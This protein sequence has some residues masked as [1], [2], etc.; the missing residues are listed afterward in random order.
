MSEEP[1]LVDWK[2]LKKLGWPYSRQN[3][4]RMIKAQRFPQPKKF[5]A[6]RGGRV[7]WRW[8]EVKHFFE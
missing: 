5:G 4:Y 3:T 6:F 2:T 8:S 1:L 7:A